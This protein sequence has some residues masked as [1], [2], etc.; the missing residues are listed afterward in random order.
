M[1][2]DPK[3]IAP[4]VNRCDAVCLIA[5]VITP[6]KQPRNT[7]SVYCVAKQGTAGSEQGNW[8]F[9]S[10]AL[11][12]AKKAEFNKNSASPGGGVFEYALKIRLSTPDWRQSATRC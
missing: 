11:T 4:R 10:V 7:Q 3:I 2:C 8:T 6:L 1:I 5:G 12:D 9:K